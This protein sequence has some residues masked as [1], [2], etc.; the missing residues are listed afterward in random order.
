MSEYG[1]KGGYQEDGDKSLMQRT[2]ENLEGDRNPYKQKREEKVR[3]VTSW[4]SVNRA[5]DRA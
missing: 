1:A 3:E 5:L 2:L 4:N